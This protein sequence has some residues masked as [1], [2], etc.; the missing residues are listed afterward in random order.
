[1][2]VS[3][4]G[5]NY[6]HKRGSGSGLGPWGGAVSPQM[7]MGQ[8]VV[9]VRLI[10][11]MMRARLNCN[12]VCHLVGRLIKDSPHDSWLVCGCTAHSMAFM[13]Q[14]VFVDFIRSCEFVWLFF[15]AKR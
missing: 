9:Q 5:F 11:Q 8:W 6:V 4:Q 2:S 15:V 7:A 10:Q 1:M 3:L 14:G 13:L 12:L